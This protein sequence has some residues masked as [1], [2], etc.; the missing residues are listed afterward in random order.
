M[1][2][3]NRIKELEAAN[4]QL[5]TENERLAD[6]N[7]KLKIANEWYLEQFRLSQHRR[8]GASSEITVLPEQLSLFNEAEVYAIDEVAEEVAGY[9]RKKRK[10][11]REEFYDGIPTEQIIYELPEDERICHECGGLLHACGHE[12]LR[13]ELEIIPAQVRAVEHVQ[14]VYSCRDCEQNSDADTLP[15]VKSTVPAPVIPGSGIASPS[16]LAF[17]L[18]NKFLLALPLARQEQELQRIGI[19]IS[20]QT[21]AKWLV[22]VAIH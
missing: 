18:C 15:M 10:G 13:R 3:D 11:N 12:V 1:K 7:V 22:F 2:N 6:E 8:F 4:A 21:M 17:I 5:K 16:L 9:T 14:T 20:R 19:H